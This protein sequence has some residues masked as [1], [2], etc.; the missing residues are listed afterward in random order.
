MCRRRNGNS[1]ITETKGRRTAGG[2]VLRKIART[3]LP[4]GTYANLR[5]WVDFVRLPEEAREE[6]RR[7]RQGLPDRDPGARA[8]IRAVTDW[9]GRAQDESRSSDG[10]FARDYSLLT[11]WNESYPE[12]SGYIV[13][14]L[15]A[16]ADFQQDERLVERARHCL[17]WLVAIQMDNGGFQGGTVSQKPR[18]AVTFNT[19]Q[20]L[21]GLAAG[22]RYW[23]DARYM[24]AM[25]AA[26]RFLRDS[27]DSDGAWRQHATPFAKEG[28][29]TYET[30]VSWGLFEA[31]RIAP[32]HGYAQA[33][34]AQ[35]GW[36][37]SRQS[38]NGWFADNDLQ[39]SLRPLTH[40]IGYALRGVIE[41]YRLSRDPVF[42]DSACRTA[43]ALIRVTELD[44]RIPGHLD[45]GWFAAAPY[46]CLTGTSQI[47]VCWFMLGRELG[48]DDYVD[49]ARRANAYV[50]RTISVEGAPDRRG[51]VKGSF[52][53]SG[54]YGQYQYLNWAAKFTLDAQRM[55]LL[56]AETAG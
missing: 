10:G 2:I 31:E 15:L 50:R 43:D 35:V 40:T 44:G 13:P 29:K 48:R 1:R 54:V 23:N 33:G 17:D 46:T 56:L 3:T 12:T 42:L 52:P 20:I 25:H 8:V 32:G 30:H 41:A 49:A 51:G 19:G 36:A 7:D 28:D 9:L 5:D 26:A 27:Q 21:I 6:C 18:I 55:E 37:L 47:A 39:D 45:S 11:G 53:V 38:A 14:T 16:E 22:A 24:N 4:D 34:L